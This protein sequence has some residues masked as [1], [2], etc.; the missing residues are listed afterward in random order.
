MRLR[1]KTA[2]LACLVL[3]IVLAPAVT[4]RGADN[5]GLFILLSN[6][7]GYDAPGLRALAEA[8]AP[9][10]TVMVSAPQEN[11]SG[12]GH[13]T[14]SREFVRVRTVEIVPGVRGW[15]IAARPATCVR[16]ALEDFL[17]GKP[18]VVVSGINRGENLGIVVNY[19]GTLGAAREAAIAGVAAIAVSNQGNDAADYKR[20]AEFIRELILQLKAGGRLKPGLFLNVNAPAGERKG[21]MVAR[22]STQAT[23]QLFTRAPSPR[24]DLYVWTDYAGRTEDQEGTD[25]WAFLNGYIAITPLQLDTTDTGSLGWLKQMKLEA[26]APAPH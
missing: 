19:S 21:V 18:D 9:L 2:A 7:D 10:G 15:A 24:G 23:P 1:T 11:N 4:A 3:V 14:T 25:V 16:M 5:G 6:D 20:T 22:Q 13:A 26:A 8:L 12:V 17:E